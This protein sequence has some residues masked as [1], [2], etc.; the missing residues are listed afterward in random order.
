MKFNKT[1]YI[2]RNKMIS[3][4]KKYVVPFIYI[5]FFKLTYDGFYYLTEFLIN[6]RT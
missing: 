6:M 4:N 1:Y 5:V 2:Y 3:L